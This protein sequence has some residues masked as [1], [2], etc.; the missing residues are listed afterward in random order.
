MLALAKQVWVG[1]N[2][3]GSV[4]KGEAMTKGPLGTEV[5]SRLRPRDGCGGWLRCRGG[6]GCGLWV[7]NS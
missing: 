3:L 1:L 5:D 4:G 2:P 7:A 6:D